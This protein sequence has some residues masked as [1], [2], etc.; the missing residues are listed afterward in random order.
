MVRLQQILV[1]KKLGFK[2]SQIKG[3]I[4]DDENKEKAEKWKQVFEME[5]EKIQ[6]EKKR[7]DEMEK[8]LHA[9]LHSLELT[10]DV[11]VDYI[12]DII[13]WN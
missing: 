10:G 2:L 7:L 4:L 8:S 9:V 6:E 1:L 5:I 13:V 12:V 11:T 3:M